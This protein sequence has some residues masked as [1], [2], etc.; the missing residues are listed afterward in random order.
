MIYHLTS[1]LN[2]SKLEDMVE[3]DHDKSNL[4]FWITVLTIQVKESAIRY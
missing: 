1:K 3:E 2:H 4:L